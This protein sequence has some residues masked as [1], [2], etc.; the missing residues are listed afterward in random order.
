ME[1]EYLFMESSCL[2]NSNVASAFVSL[3]EI[4]NIELKCSRNNNVMLTNNDGRRK[5]KCGGNRSKDKAD[6]A[7]RNNSYTN[8]SSEENNNSS[9]GVKNINVRKSCISDSGNEVKNKKPPLFF[10]G[11]FSSIFVTIHLF[12]AFNNTTFN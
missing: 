3:I 1:N 8:E 4:T 10:G 11:P 5:R 7:N 12:I 6:K 2:K 9:F